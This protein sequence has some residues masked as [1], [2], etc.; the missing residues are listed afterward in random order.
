MGLLDDYEKIEQGRLLYNYKESITAEL[1][2]I[3]SRLDSMVAAK[4]KHPEAVVEIDG[5]IAQAK[6]ALNNLAKQY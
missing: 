6:T 5:L 1:Q 3:K 4:S 2:Q